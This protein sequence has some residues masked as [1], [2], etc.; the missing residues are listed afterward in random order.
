MGCGFALRVGLGVRD[1]RQTVRVAEALRQGEG[2]REIEL[3]RIVT[4]V[5]GDLFADGQR[6][7]LD[8]ADVQVLDLGVRLVSRF[9]ILRIGCISA[10]RVILVVA[11]LNV[12]FG[13]TVLVQHSVFVVLRQTSIGVCPR[14]CVFVPCGLYRPVVRIPNDF[15]IILTICTP[16]QRQIRL[17]A[18]AALPGLGA[19]DGDGAGQGVGEV[20][21][22]CVIS[23][24]N[25]ILWFR[26]FRIT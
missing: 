20:G 3:P 14:A 17:C 1:R 5:A 26:L 2:D 4:A 16:V 8:V 10:A 22:L 18:S 7:A 9:V 11:V 21:A 24:S 12:G 15:P 19:G 25:T 13:D 6:A 23:G